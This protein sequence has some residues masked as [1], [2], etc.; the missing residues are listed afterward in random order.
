MEQLIRP[1]RVNDARYIHQI[2][3]QEQVMP[4]VVSLPSDRVEQLEDRYRTLPKNYHEFVAQLDDVVVGHAGLVQL[5]GRRSHVGTFYIA[6]DTNYHCK[7]IGTALITKI[8]D[9]ADNWLM[10]ER[11]ELGVLVTN[12]RAQALYE[13]HGFVVEGK[14]TGAIRSAGQY[15]DEVVMSRLRPKGILSR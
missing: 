3:S 14:K 8:L 1:V 10:L 6:V 5:S 7:G 15:V 4:Y 9:L 13:R 11:V 2:L 12:P